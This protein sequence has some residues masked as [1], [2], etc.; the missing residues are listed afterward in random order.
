M[1]SD[2]RHRLRVVR[3]PTSF[4][5]LSSDNQPLQHS[6]IEAIKWAVVV[7]FVSIIV[8]ILKSIS[9]ASHVHTYYLPCQTLFADADIAG[10]KRSICMHIYATPDVYVH[11]KLHRWWCYLAAVSKF[12]LRRSGILPYE[13]KDGRWHTC[14]ALLS[15]SIFN[16][17]TFERSLRKSKAFYYSVPN[18]KSY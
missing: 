10:Q 7:S 12:H 18:L 6:D 15:F 13:N 8:V 9:V 3:H 2:R 5:V 14:A 4:C 16:S 1:F 17:A 11:Q